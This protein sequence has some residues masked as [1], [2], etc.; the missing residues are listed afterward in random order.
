[1]IS[2]DS[3]NDE[4]VKSEEWKNSKNYILFL[5]YEGTVAI[6]NKWK[7]KIKYG[8]NKKIPLFYL[9]CGKYL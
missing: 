5:R 2:D 1:M 6:Q 9:I 4:S 8:Q 7:M 3:V